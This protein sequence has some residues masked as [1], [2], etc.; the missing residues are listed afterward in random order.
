VG[1]RCA[2]LRLEDAAGREALRHRKEWGRAV[3]PATVSL[4]FDTFFTDERG[5]LRVT[6]AQEIASQLARLVTEVE[7][8]FRWSLYAGSVLFLRDAASSSGAR[9]ALVDFSYSYPEENPGHDNLLYGL[10]QL[11]ARLGEWLAARAALQVRTTLL[12]VRAEGR[13]LLARKKRGLGVDKW[14]G[15]GGKLNAGESEAAAAARECQEETGLAVSAAGVK[16]CGVVEFR[17]VDR[18]AWD[19]ECHLFVAEYRA[20]MGEPRETEEMAPRWFDEE[21]LPWDDMWPDDRIWLPRVL[22]GETDL[23]YRFWHEAASSQIV[24]F[25]TVK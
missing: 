25:D 10:R 23:H 11:A 13:L 18:P 4:L 20:T 17:F 7:Q 3:V 1:F 8:R 19:S 24:R 12:F 14:N 2:G 16:H 15:P 22:R 9:V 5:T 21:S 6:E